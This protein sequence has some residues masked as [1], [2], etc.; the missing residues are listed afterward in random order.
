MLT[1]AGEA[2]TP[3]ANHR[4]LTTYAQTHAAA[5]GTLKLSTGLGR[6][7]PRPRVEQQPAEWRTRLFGVRRATWHRWI[8]AIDRSENTAQ[9]GRHAAN[10]P[11]GQVDFDRNGVREVT[12]DL[13][14]ERVSKVLFDAVNEAR[15]DVSPRHRERI[16]QPRRA[17]LTIAVVPP[18]A[19][20]E[21][22]LPHADGAASSALEDHVHTEANGLSDH[23]HNEEQ[24]ASPSIIVP[25][26]V[27]HV[28]DL[29]RLE[30]HL[31]HLPE[32]PGRILARPGSYRYSMS[33]A[34]KSRMR[35]FESAMPSNGFMAPLLGKHQSFGSAAIIV[36]HRPLVSSPLQ[37]EMRA[38]RGRCRR[39]DAH[40]SFSDLGFGQRVVPC[41]SEGDHRP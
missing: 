10:N 22:A 8:R 13:R 2:T 5:C 9:S 30:H 41:G 20:V 11:S 15:V 34:P 19:I 29:S 37:S 36:A 21:V 4:A 24:R 39:R 6:L 14:I 38:R 3:R 32:I 31:F 28:L 26:Q 23:L 7:S 40:A 25:A 27:T 1:A 16:Q 18:E 33:D 35:N 17:N 12:A